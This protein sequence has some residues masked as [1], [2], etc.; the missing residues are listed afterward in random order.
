MQRMTY[1]PA[2]LQRLLFY[3]KNSF[4][5]IWTSLC[6]FV[7]VITQYQKWINIYILGYPCDFYILIILEKLMR[8]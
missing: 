1:M 7:M 4:F 2:N 3:I 8:K 6:P 5:W